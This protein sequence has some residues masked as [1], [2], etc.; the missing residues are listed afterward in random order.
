MIQSYA[1][2]LSPVRHE[3]IPGWLTRRCLTVAGTQYGIK[4]ARFVLEHAMRRFGGT[5]NA[6][7][8]DHWGSTRLPDGTVALVSEPYGIRPLELI[9][10]VEFCTA[11]SLNVSVH[12]ASEWNPSGGTIRILITPKVER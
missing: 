6:G 12:A 4:S 11:L 5:L 2:P 1:P 10:M 9:A 7:W 8:L 3:H